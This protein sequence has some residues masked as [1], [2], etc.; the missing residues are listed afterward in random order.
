M[1]EMLESE[2]REV[3]STQRDSN[4]H[5]LTFISLRHEIDRRLLL[6]VIVCQIAI[7]S[8]VHCC[9][10]HLPSLFCQPQCKPIDL[11]EIDIARI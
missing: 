1:I 8:S 6:N 9:C 4:G 2:P 5:A 10:Q 11:V 7:A 3:L